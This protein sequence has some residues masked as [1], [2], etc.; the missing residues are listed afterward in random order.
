MKPEASSFS[1]ERTVSWGGEH[2][3]VRLYTANPKHAD[4]THQK[5]R[6]GELEQPAWLMLHDSGRHSAP[7][8]AFRAGASIHVMS[9]G[10]GRERGWEQ[11]EERNCC[12]GCPPLRT[13]RY[14]TKRVWKASALPLHRSKCCTRTHTHAHTHRCTPPKEQLQKT[15]LSLERRKS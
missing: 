11:G 13:R 4:R 2:G 8:A 10:C 7:S 15:E 5:S 12:A 6:G 3:D 1:E 9:P 14:Y